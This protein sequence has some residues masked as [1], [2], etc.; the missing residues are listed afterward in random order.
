MAKLN[1]SLNKKKISNHKLFLLSLPED[2]EARNHNSRLFE[3]KDIYKTNS[4]V[5]EIS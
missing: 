5:Q 1:H 4:V 2:L 3:V